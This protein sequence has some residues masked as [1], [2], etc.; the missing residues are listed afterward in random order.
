MVTDGQVRC[1]FRDLGLGMPLVLAARRAGMS[2]KTARHYRNKKMLPSVRKKEGPPRLYRTRVDPFAA[3][4]AEVEEQLRVQP[5]LRTKTLFEWLRQMHPGEFFDSHRRTFERRVRQWRAMHGPSKTI[6]FRQVHQPGDLAA[7]DF[8]CMNSLD[9]TICGRPFDHLVYHF[10]LTYSNWESVTL[11]ASESFEAL[12]DGLQNALWELGGVPKR[13]RTDSLSAAVNNLSAT[14]EFQTRYRDLLAHYGLSPQRINVRQAHENGDAESAHGHFKLHVEQALLLRGSGDFA[15]REEYGSFLNQLVATR[16]GNR[17]D[18]AEEELQVL[19]DLPDARLSSCL[20][21]PCRVDSGSLIHIHRNTYSV[22]SRLRGE[23]VE[24]R[25]FADRVEVWYAD[26]LVDTLPRLVGRD[27]HAVHYRHVIDSLVRKPGAFANYAYREDLFPTTRFRIAY[28]RFC[29]GRDERRGAKD[30]LKIL[31]HAALTNETAVD[32]AL[33]V[34]LTVDG[35]L[36]AEA[37]IELAKSAAELPAATAVVVEAPDLSEFDGLLTFTEETHGQDANGSSK[38]GSNEPVDGSADGTVAGAAVAGVSGSFPVAGRACGEGEPE[39]PAIPRGTSQPRMR[40]T[41]P[42]TD[43][44]HGGGVT[45]SSGQDL[46]SIPLVASAKERPAT[47]PGIA[48]RWILEASRERFGVRETGLGENPRAVCG[49]RATG[50]AGA[51]GTVHHQQPAGPKPAGREAGA[52]A[53]AVSKEAGWLRGIA[54]RRSWLRP[55]EPRR[56]GGALHAPG[57]S[58]RAWECDADEQPAVLAM[59]RDLQG[60]HDDGGGD[61]SIG[62]P[63]RHRRAQCAELPTGMRKGC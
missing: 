25:L 50:H 12:S 55:A 45:S 21:V 61:R 60:S 19:R 5:R 27:R 3:V 47:V 34:L 44:P 8:T 38:Q 26:R 28:D 39:L 59:D 48:R 14:R 36:T 6:V 20:K 16:N 1:L 11:C 54:D 40:S 42:G 53:G 49:R 33:R 62:A 37:V 57:G 22:H 58:L 41:N 51:S 24:A 63:Q 7:S 30:Y 18:R 23:I 52:E 4:W 2:P 31:Q 13:H 35:R 29:D 9:V 15:S 10:V 46:G 43:S 56:N 17:R 32:D